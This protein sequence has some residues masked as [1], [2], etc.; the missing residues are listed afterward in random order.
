MA[1]SKMESTATGEEPQKAKESAL[2][3]LEKL[4]VAGKA[5]PIDGNMD[6]GFIPVQPLE[7]PRSAEQKIEIATQPE[8]KPATGANLFPTLEPEASPRAP[9][10][11]VSTLE[12]PVPVLE[13][14]A[15]EMKDPP[16]V[17]MAPQKKVKIVTRRDP[18]RVREDPTLDSPVLATIAKGSL[19]PFVQE[20]NGWY[21]IEFSAGE[22]GWV[23]KKYSQL[24][25]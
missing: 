17:A 23:S 22:M 9:E 21:K 10:D 20:E 13:A 4:D 25:E 18:L 16:E 6:K 8:P 2:E 14:P 3:A 19:V 24:V 12:V 5:A 7:V 1:E 15:P 11:S